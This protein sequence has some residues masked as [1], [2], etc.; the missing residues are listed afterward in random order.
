[1]KS[2]DRPSRRMCVCIRRKRVVELVIVWYVRL[3]KSQAEIRQKVVP[4]GF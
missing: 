1:M 4:P 2:C 3:G